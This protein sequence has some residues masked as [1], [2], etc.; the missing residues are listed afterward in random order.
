MIFI[1]PAKT[2]KNWKQRIINYFRADKIPMPTP[3]RYPYSLASALLGIALPLV[4]CGITY[5][6]LRDALLVHNNL[7]VGLIVFADLVFLGLLGFVLIKRLAPALQ[8][9][10]ALELNEQGIIDYTRNIVIEW[11]YIKDLDHEIGRN[12]SRIIIKLKHETEY[13]SEVVLRQRWI[14]GKDREI[15]DEVYAYFEEIKAI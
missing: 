7:A 3:I 6:N 9:K 4:F 8:R 12:S 13:G 2:G 15:F 5:V 1:Y 14:K 11:S 10:I